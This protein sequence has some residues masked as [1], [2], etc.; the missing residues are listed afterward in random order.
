MQL[1]E[2]S[3][4][5]RH[6]K[7]IVAEQILAHHV[8]EY[9]KPRTSRRDFRRESWRCLLKGAPWTESPFFHLFTYAGNGIYGTISETEDVLGR[10]IAFIIE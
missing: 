3:P 9:L 10:V 4:V 7:T 1:M 8:L 2:A 5:G 6:L